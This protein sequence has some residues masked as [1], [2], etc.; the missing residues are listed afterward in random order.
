MNVPT[1]KTLSLTA[2][3][4]YWRNPRDNHAAIDKV[5][6]SIERYGY[7]QL[8]AV[9][10]KNVIVAG[11]TRYLALKELGYKKVQV[12]VLDLSAKQAKAY[13]IVD[14]KTAEFASWTGDLATELRELGEIG[15]LQPFFA[16]NLAELMGQSVGSEGAKDV[17]ADDI[18]KSREA[19]NY[20]AAHKNADKE[21]A[22]P[23]CGHE[24]M[25]R[26]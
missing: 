18:D 19:L 15:D 8:I 22:C 17:T 16:E 13:R 14:N 7:N 21:V 1:T 26:A 3:K 24:F 11:H 12:L 6:Q 2:I 23:E 25:V 5:K 20:N 9:D 10:K 4:P